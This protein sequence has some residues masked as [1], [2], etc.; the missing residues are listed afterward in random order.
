M[1]LHLMAAQNQ[2]LLDNFY[3][4]FARHDAKAMAA[5]YHREATFRDPAFGELRGREIGAMWQMLIARSN[6]KLQITSTNIIADENS[7]TANWTAKYIFS[8]TSRK[9]TNHVT[10]TFEFKDGLILCHTDDFN[11]HRWAAQALGWKG[12][13]LGGTGF[14][15][16]KVMQQTRQSLDWY[17]AKIKN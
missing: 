3:S 7:G 8:K 16:R 12:W 15:R 4:A 2:T 11:F 5:N 17:I 1:N 9:V 13:L 6:G 10:A 14:F